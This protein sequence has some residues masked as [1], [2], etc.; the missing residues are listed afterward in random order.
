MLG[1]ICCEGVPSLCQWY[2][3]VG[4]VAGVVYGAPGMVG[5]AQGVTKKTEI[6]R[7][8]AEANVEL[9]IARLTLGWDKTLE[10]SLVLSG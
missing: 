2:G 6:F 4:A 1:I 5:G 9:V 7:L 10:M 8:Q 3:W